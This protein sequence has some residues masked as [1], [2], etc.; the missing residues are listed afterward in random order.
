MKNFKSWGIKTRKIGNYEATWENLEI[1][2]IGLKDFPENDPELVRLEKRK[3]GITLEELLGKT[4]PPFQIDIDMDG[5]YE[6]NF[7]IIKTIYSKEIVPSYTTSGFLMSDLGNINSN[8]YSL[9][10][11]LLKLTKNYVGFVYIRWNNKDYQLKA[12]DNYVHLA[13]TNVILVFKINSIKD[14]ESFKKIHKVYKDSVHKFILDTSLVLDK[15]PEKTILGVD[16]KTIYIR[17]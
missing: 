3:K 7:E 13:N 15:L 5:N 9:T 6:E 14:Y 10:N 1:K 17:P 2:R 4:N 12:I 8:N 11:N 16:F